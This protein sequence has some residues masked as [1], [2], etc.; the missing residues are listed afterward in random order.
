MKTAIFF[1]VSV[2]ILKSNSFGQDNSTSKNETVKII[3]INLTIFENFK[4]RQTFTGYNFSNRKIRIY[5]KPFPKSNYKEHLH[6]IHKYNSKELFLELSRLNLSSLKEGYYN[7]CMDSSNGKDYT[8]IITAKSKN[9]ST[10]IHHFYI[11]E[12]D[13][14]VAVLN[15]YLPKLFQIKY[16]DKETKQN[17]IKV[18]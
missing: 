1:F 13:K 9:I 18:E 4:E 17:C 12:I 6:T 11:D 7:N 10:K 2:L 5:D 15:R 8:I 3:N 16:L 14:L